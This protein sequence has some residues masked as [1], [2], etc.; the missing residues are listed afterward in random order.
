MLDRIYENGLQESGKTILKYG[1]N[2]IVSRDDI[3]VITSAIRD[4]MTN[5][6]K[7][8]VSSGE[9]VN[10]CVKKWLSYEIEQ[11]RWL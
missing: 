3:G 9:A 5:S 7:I 1:A 11:K 10:M 8:V 6:K 2:H 4:T